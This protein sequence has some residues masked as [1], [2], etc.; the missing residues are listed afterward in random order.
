MTAATP[1]QSQWRSA[2]PP[3]SALPKPDWAKLLTRVLETPRPALF[4]TGTDTDVG[5]TYI[6][7]RL[8]SA[9]LTQNH[10]VHVLKPVQTGINLHTPAPA[11]GASTISDVA[12]VLS[13]LGEATPALSGE[14]LYTFTEPATPSVADTLGE[15][16][17]ATLI[18]ACQARLTPGR[19]LLI[20]G[21]GG[22]RVPV[23]PTLDM[24]GLIQALGTPV[25]LVTR[26]NLG[27]INHTRLSLDALQHAGCPVLGVV[28]NAA[29]PLNLQDAALRLLPSVLTDYLNVPVLG[30]E[31]YVP[32]A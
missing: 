28:I 10:P 22:L 18:A 17:D 11:P 20:E 12:R 29:Q 24:L 23:T 25:L 19:L 6:T 1:P 21:A 9:A 26:P 27:T 2:A 3:L 16:D 14:T 13:A 31:P 5:K 7:Q 32:A 15:L 30:F 4:I 8:A